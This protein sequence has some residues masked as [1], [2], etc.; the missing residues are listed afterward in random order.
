[1][2]CSQVLKLQ[3]RLEAKDARLAEVASQ[4]Q[5]AQAQ[6][7]HGGGRA[8]LAD[9]SNCAALAPQ[10]PAQKPAEQ[11]PASQVAADACLMGC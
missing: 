2:Q 9:I 7:P 8:S 3:N 1:M 4:L 11:V 5:A 10:P 6:A